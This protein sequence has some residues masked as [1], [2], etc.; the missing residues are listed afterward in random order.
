MQSIQL[1]TLDVDALRTR[2]EE[3]SDE[4]LLEFGSGAVYGV[5]KSKHG[6][7]TAAGFRAA[8]GGGAC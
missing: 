1:A 3:M 8:A 2:L 6:Q 5:S 7:T 4:E